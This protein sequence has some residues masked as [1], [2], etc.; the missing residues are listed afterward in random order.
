MALLVLANLGL[1]VFDLT[2]IKARNWYLK[3]GLYLQERTLSPQEQYVQKVERLQELLKQEGLQSPIVRELLLE[4]QQLSEEIFITNPPFRLTNR[5]GTLASIQALFRERIELVN[6]EATFEEAVTTFWSAEYLERQGWENELEFFQ[7]QIRYLILFYEPVLPYDIIKGIEPYRDSQEYLITVT[8]LKNE[9]EEKGLTGERVEPLLQ[10]LRDKS[11]ELIDS[12]YFFQLVNKTSNLTKIKYKVKNHI[13]DRDPE[14]YPSLPPTLKILESIN[15]L[16]YIAPEVLWA[17]KSSK[18]A[19]NTYWSL[20]NFALNGWQGELEYFDAEIRFLMRSFYFRNIGID[21]EFVDR[22]WLIDLPWMALFFLEFLCRTLWLSFRTSLSWWGAVKYRWYDVLLLQPWL[23]I[24]RVITAIIRLD[25]VKI[26]NLE[27]SK[28]YLGLSF[29]ASFGKE[30][31]QVV[32]AQG[33]DQLQNTV[34]KGLIKKALFERKEGGKKAK[35]KEDNPTIAAIVNEVLELT[36]CEVLPEVRTDLED[37]LDYQVEKALEKSTIYRQIRRI[38][39]VRRLP[40]DIANKIAGQI[41]AAIAT[42]PEKAYQGSPPDPQGSALKE[43]LVKHFTRELTSKLE[44]EGTAEEIELLL[45]DWLEDI[46]VK[47]LNQPDVL[48]LPSSQ[49]ETPKQILPAQD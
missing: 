23:P 11:T 29:I 38:P 24:L 2:Y 47:Y 35:L 6:P 36:A 32:I 30:V 31:T 10:E 20:P 25:Q 41:S 12:E 7:N 14:T 18:E 21:G 39:L 4:L 13:Y 42:G 48:L 26:L 45:I 43:R 9:L 16:E 33:I 15:V 17:D 5:Y 34:G 22:F 3:A 1:V 37:F 44:R 49:E 28:R 46:K 8:L 40:K 27:T 19:F